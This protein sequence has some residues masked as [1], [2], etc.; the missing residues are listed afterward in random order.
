MDDVELG[1]LLR[2]AAVYGEECV[3]DV[4]RIHVMLQ[5]VARSV[6]KAYEADPS[7]FTLWPPPIPDTPHAIPP[8]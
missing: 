7:M 8:P 6:R 1:R 2:M 5:D 4:L 3:A